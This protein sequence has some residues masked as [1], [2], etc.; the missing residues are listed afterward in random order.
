MET[1]FEELKVFMSGV[2]SVEEWN[3]KREQAKGIF[4]SKLINELDSSGYIK[5]VLKKV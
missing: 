5:K 1:N 2:K 3:D 4:H